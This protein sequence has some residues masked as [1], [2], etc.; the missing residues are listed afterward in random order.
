MFARNSIYS[1]FYIVSQSALFVKASILSTEIC[2]CVIY[3]ETLKYWVG[4]QWGQPYLMGRRCL[5]PLGWTP[6]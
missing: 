3:P 1:Q 4:V 5:F 6:F 2:F